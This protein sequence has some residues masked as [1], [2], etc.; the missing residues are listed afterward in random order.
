MDHRYISDFLEQAFAG[1]VCRR[2]QQIHEQIGIQLSGLSADDRLWVAQQQ[3]LVYADSR[4]S[5]VHCTR[6]LNINVDSAVRLSVNLGIFVAQ[7][8][9]NW[10]ETYYVL[11]TKV[12]IKAASS[13]LN[14][15]ESVGN[16]HKRLSPQVHVP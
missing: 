15:I 1:L 13:T 11:C 10:A 14:T 3:L 16:N 7:V 9:V 5:R 12:Q 2:S 6:K 4:Y 8:I